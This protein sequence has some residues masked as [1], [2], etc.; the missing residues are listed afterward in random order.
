MPKESYVKDNYAWYNPS[1][2]QYTKYTGG[3]DVN[4]EISDD[5]AAFNMGGDW[6]M[7]TIAQIKELM[8]NCTFSSTTYNDVPGIEY[9]S[10]ING[11]T[12][13][14]P[15]SKVVGENAE[16]VTANYFQSALTWSLCGKISVTEGRTGAIGQCFDVFEGEPENYVVDLYYG[17]PVRGVIGEG[18]EPEPDP[19]PQEPL[20]Q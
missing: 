7:P 19:Q 16:D 3:S 2:G 13:F 15:G 8:D 11:E 14:F 12:L 4:L 20:A 9:T 6:H 1:T 5:A 18:S 10:S 17:M